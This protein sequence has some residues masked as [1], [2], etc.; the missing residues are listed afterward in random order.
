MLSLQSGTQMLAS[1][2]ASL[3][4]ILVTQD[5]TSIWVEFEIFSSVA[6]ISQVVALPGHLPCEIYLVLSYDLIRFY[7]SSKEKCQKFKPVCTKPI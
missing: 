4:F 5:V 6:K 2:A 7:L 1:K 3:H